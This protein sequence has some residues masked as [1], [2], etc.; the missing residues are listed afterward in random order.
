LPWRA[1]GLLLAVPAPVRDAVYDWI[2]RHRYRWFGRSDTCE[3]PSPR[4][5]A[6]LIRDTE[7]DE[8][9]I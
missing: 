7:P 3:I 5:R 6:R 1:L 2:A 4:V 8:G 9:P